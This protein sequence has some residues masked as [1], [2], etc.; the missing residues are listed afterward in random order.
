[1]ASRLA[2]MHASPHGSSEGASMAGGARLT[3][4][5][6]PVDCK[7]GQRRRMEDGGHGLRRMDGERTQRR[8]STTSADRVFGRTTS[9]WTDDSVCG[10][11]RVR[12][13]AA[14]VRV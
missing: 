14:R 12:E 2:L 8:R 11:A 13:R 6:L 3:C 1:M 9:I 4:P 7:V 10:R 5:P